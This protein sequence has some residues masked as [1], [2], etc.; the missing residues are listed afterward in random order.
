MW[1][2]LQNNYGAISAITGIATLGVWA[3]YFQ[4]LLSNYRRNTR[5]KIL[6][7]RGA[8]HKPGAH[9]LIS[10]MSAAAI[11]VEAILTDVK[12][13]SDEE[14]ALSSWMCSLS[15][16]DLEVDETRD[17]RTQWYQGP[18]A[19]GEMMD[20]GPYAKLLEQVAENGSI[21]G[22]I[23][24]FTIIVIATYTA[25]DL[26][27]AARRTFDVRRDLEGDFIVPRSFTAEQI[28]SRAAR[29][30]LERFMQGRP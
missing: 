10:N 14:G 19:T 3:L 27:V 2:W 23:S 8:G 20:V 17:K 18:L 22:P 21:K 9:C 16:L 28:R 24:E 29:R 11:Y 30:S 26:I 12:Y 15:D 13:R 25:E 5:S 4:L 6:I 7:N 1:I